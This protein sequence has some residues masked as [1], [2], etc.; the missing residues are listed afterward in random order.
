MSF[1]VV[2]G[3]FEKFHIFTKKYVSPIFLF[4]VWFADVAYIN[5]APC[6]PSQLKI[7][8]DSVKG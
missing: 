6:R 2:N 1:S 3:V 5:D 8:W 7:V 4:F